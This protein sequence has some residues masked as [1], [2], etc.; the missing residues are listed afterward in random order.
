MKKVLFTTMILNL[1][2]CN[3]QSKQTQEQ[4]NQSVKANTTEKLASVNYN[5]I[6]E[7]KEIN[8]IKI[9]LLEIGTLN[10]PSGKIVVCDPLVFYQPTPYTKMVPP[11]KY[12]MKI[13]VAKTEDSGDRYA[14]AQLEISTKKAVKWILAVTENDNV[15]ELQEKDAF[16]GFPVDTGL[17][18][19]FDYQTSLAFDKFQNDFYKQEPAKNIYD[20]YFEAEFKKNSVPKDNPNAV[21]NWIN[22]TLP[23]TNLNIAMFQSGY[24]DGYYPAYWGIDENGT[25]TSLVLDFFVIDLPSINN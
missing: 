3:S 6:L 9:E 13:Y 21:G 18:G 20:D 11:G 19:F 5:L 24:G 22:Y 25:V 10:V 12:P 2:S 15:N 1:F 7:N 23:Q 8:G 17:A 16:F 4:K 14:I